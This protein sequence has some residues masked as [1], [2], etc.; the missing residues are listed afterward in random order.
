MILI[1]LFLN[2]HLTF[3]SRAGLLPEAPAVAVA[4][5]DARHLLGQR[6][7]QRPHGRAHPHPLQEQQRHLPGNRSVV[8]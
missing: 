8:S 4:L 1:G 6:G 7:R 3:F 5:L 2:K